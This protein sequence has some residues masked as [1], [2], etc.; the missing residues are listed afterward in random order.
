VINP[1]Q[2]WVANWNNKPALGWD[3]FDNFKFGSIHRVELLQDRMR[4]LLGGPARARL[5]DIVDVIR[6][7]ATRDARAVY[8]GPMMT[9]WA[10]ARIGS[11]GSDEAA[12]LQAVDDW[13]ASGAHR[14]NTDGDDEMDD[15]VPLVVFDT[16]YDIAVHAIFDDE[17]GGD[18]DQ[19]IPVPISDYAPAEGS[20]FFFDY[21]SYLDVLFDGAAAKDR[22]E[23]DYC[24]D[25]ETGRKETCAEVVSAALEAAVATVK[26]DQGDDMSEWSKEAEN[27]VFDALGAGSVDEIPW[28]NRGTHNHVV[29]IL[30]PGSG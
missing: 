7:A 14:Y 10:E 17:L 21:S 9:Q 23:L 3:N 11:S 19:I 15:P 6:D 5:S 24:D 30:S 20:S 8:L 16:W 4:E 2:G 13:V 27:I 29:E 25:R 18:F 26:E 28:Q 22:F 1:D 12:A